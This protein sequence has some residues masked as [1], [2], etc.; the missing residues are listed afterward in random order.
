MKRINERLLIAT[1]TRAVPHEDVLAMMKPLKNL[2]GEER[3]RL[4][5]QIAEE[6]ERKYPL[7]QDKEGSECITDISE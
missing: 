2:D 5:N 3:L 4:Q 6:I 1:T 7:R